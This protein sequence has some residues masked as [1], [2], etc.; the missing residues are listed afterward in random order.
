MG[1]LALNVE[2]LCFLK[3]WIKY[4]HLDSKSLTTLHKIAKWKVYWVFQQQKQ[5]LP[6]IK[7]TYRRPGI[8]YRV[9]SLLTR[10]ITAKG[11]ILEG[12]K[13]VNSN[14]PKLMKR[15]NCLVRTDGLILIVKNLS[16]YKL[17]LKVNVNLPYTPS[18][19]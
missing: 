12:L 14:L 13:H 18:P 6:C 2:K 7:W 17:K 3:S 10:Y 16:Y 5:K 11:I 8:D 9:A 19:L 15:P 4:L 1:G